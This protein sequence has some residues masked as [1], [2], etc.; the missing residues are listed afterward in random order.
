MA[1]ILKKENITINSVLPTFVPTG[2]APPA[3]VGAFPKENITPMSTILKCFNI[4]IDDD[5]MNGEIGECSLET[6]YL[7]KQPQYSNES[8]RWERE[9]VGNVW[10]LV[11]PD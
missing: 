3:L 7:R 11:Y 6:V 4:F 8:Q 9:G 1:P 10:P 2:L 5:E